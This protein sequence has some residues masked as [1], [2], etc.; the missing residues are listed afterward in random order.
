MLNVVLIGRG[1]IATEVLKHIPPGGG[2]SVTGV[3]VRPERISDARASLP[4]TIEVASA[5]GDFATAPH[6]IA[7]CAGH[8]AV[9]GSAKRR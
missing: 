8:G 1:A 6:L 9:A 7:E 2:V 4:P 5:I 3:I